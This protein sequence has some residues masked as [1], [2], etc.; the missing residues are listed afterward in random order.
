MKK[1]I[2]LLLITGVITACN[3]VKI[4]SPD[5]FDVSTSATKYT[6]RDTVLFTFSGNPD[7]I[8]MYSG[9]PTHRY[10]NKDRTSA[11]PDS[12]IMNFTTATTAPST[13]TQ[14]VAIN[15]VS[16][17]LSTNYSG[18]LDAA[19]IQNATWTDITARA[20]FATTTTAVATG[21][22]HL[23]DLR[24]ATSPLYIAFKYIA[25]TATATSVSRK[26]TLSALSIKS[27]FKDTS[28]FLASTATIGGFST[29]GFNHIY[30]ILNPI[31]TW[32]FANGTLTFNAPAIASSKDE[33][34]AISRPLDITII[35][36]DLGIILKNSSVRL[37]QYKYMFKTPGTYT[38]TFLAQNI[39]SDQ[40][41]QV[42]KQ[43]TLTITN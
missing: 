22:I 36:R 6:I 19:S 23:E 34:W 25:D 38:V 39:S 28:N 18:S 43:I 30:S 13:I 15:N 3:K 9:E 10:E 27:M 29:G 4:T 37:S 7:E 26:W 14:P 2:F 32:V 24:S 41:I 21:N 31:N 40:A 5:S 17:L 42:I 1:I 16:V 12:C 35:P 33:D 8:T 20:K 11:I